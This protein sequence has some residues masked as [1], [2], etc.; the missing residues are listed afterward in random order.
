MLTQIV[1]KVETAFI[2]HSS[3]QISEDFS[4]C[5]MA[6][7]L[8]RKCNTQTTS[9]QMGR[10]GKTK[11]LR[12]SDLV[13]QWL[14]L[15]LHPSRSMDEGLLREAAISQGQLHHQSLPQHKKKHTK[16]GP[17]AHYTVCRDLSRVETVLPRRLSWP[18]PLPG[19]YFQSQLV[20]E[21]LPAVPF[22]YS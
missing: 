20:R 12:K 18:K 14:L 2:S 21:W 6:I 5:H 10:S 11:V 8:L 22:A 4:G 1:Q 15:G 7:L 17:G 19:V 9:P 3:L 16:L 13:N